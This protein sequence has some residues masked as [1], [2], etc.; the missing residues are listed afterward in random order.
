MSSFTLANG[1]RT[2]VV[3]DPRADGVQVTVRYEVGAADDPAGQEG[4]A[5]LAEHVTFDEQDGDQLLSARLSSA[6]MYFNAET[7]LD[8][9]TYISRA[10]PARLDD[11]IAIEAARMAAPCESISDA[12]FAREREVVLNE[13]RERARSLDAI[14]AITNELYPA[15]HPYHR[16]PSGTLESVGAITR[17]QVC[18]FIAGHYATSTAVVV[19]S[20]NLTPAGA[21][22]ALEHT[23]GRVAAR[24]LAKP[25]AISPP[26]ID[27]KEVAVP[28]PLENDSLVVTWALPADPAARA[29]FHAVLETAAAVIDSKLRASV[30]LLE[31]G[32]ERAPLMGLL[33]LGDG[34]ET[35]SN[36]INGAYYTLKDLPDWL[37]HQD[38]KEL[39]PLAFGALQHHALYRL[40][41]ALDDARSRDPRIAALIAEGRDPGATLRT[42][43]D[44]VT[45]MT[46]EEAIEI[47]RT[48]IAYKSA[49]VMTLE[50]AGTN[51]VDHF[52]LTTAITDPDRREPH[53]DPA[54]AHHA[55]VAAPEPPHEV[56]RKLANGLE[57]VLL[58]LSSVPTI[59]VRLVFHAGSADEPSD[60]PGV[61]LLAAHDLGWQPRDAKDLLLFV[62][63]GGVRHVDV[64][65]DHTT[66]EIVGMSS[67]LDYLLAGL[68]RWVRD[69]SYIEETEGFAHR[70]AVARAHHDQASIASDQLRAAL[71]GQRH[72]YAKAGLLREARET[73]G[74]EEA[75]AFYAAHYTPDN[76]ALI[77]SGHFDPAL[78]DRW[79]DYLFADWRGHALARTAPEARPHP[80]SFARIA[81]GAQVEL[82]IMLPAKAGSHASQ[83]IAAAMLDEVAGDVRRQLGASYDLDAMLSEQR[84][85]TTYV[86]AGAID[87]ARTTEAVKF[88]AERI[89]RLRA[90]PELATRLF[91]EARDRVL[92]RLSTTENLVDR[93]ES[94]LD[95]G[96]D[97]GSDVAT[98][99]D[100]TIDQL[101]LTDLDLARAVIS[102]RGAKDQLLPAFAAL[103]RDPVVIPPIPTS[104]DDVVDKPP[105]VRPYRDTSVHELDD[106]L[107]SPSQRHGAVTFMAAAGTSFGTRLTPATQ[108]HDLYWG[109]G[110]TIELGYRGRGPSRVGVHF[111]VASLNGGDGDARFTATDVGVLGQTRFADRFWAGLTAG[112]H[113]EASADGF[114][115]GGELG[116]DLA[117][118]HGRWLTAFAEYEIVFADPDQVTLW[119]A[120]VGWGR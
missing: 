117:P 48:Q 77:I 16:R 58:P 113:F 45:A 11:L 110:L 19:I 119:T 17:A 103:G 85:A 40:Y 60:Q 112:R 8:A 118:I 27:A 74:E 47:S 30:K 63:A 62:T 108:H 44:A 67:Q 100:L 52:A 96:R 89:A 46:R 33:I 92:A 69:G 84:L 115:L 2:A 64:E 93:L 97:A 37:A 54:A 18:A 105:V 41:G 1:V 79:I 65:P 107:T 53:A 75:S 39:D 7:T 87:A 99:R 43:V 78:V 26:R 24:E 80:A 20:G 50:A 81:E 102:M 114:T 25:P 38:V 42:E 34:T 104:D 101:S 72:P 120:G 36:L 55:A 86:I 106:P 4:I 57:V 116:I 32:D 51:A 90:D 111:G 71:Y 91:V 35:K 88:L 95:A 9:T 109:P 94:D 31:L 76:A 6:A 12:Q 49:N 28:A 61:S 70:V 15:Q 5:H 83:L 21:R 66:F 56:K 98:V 68:R 13:L 82:E 73:L 23:L 3:T 10:H 22:A 14:T 59:D 29:K